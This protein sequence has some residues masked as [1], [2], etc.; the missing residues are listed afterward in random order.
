ME[1]DGHVFSEST[2][3][4]VVGQPREEKPVQLV[5][6]VGFS[7][8]PVIPLVPLPMPV[9]VGGTESSTPRHKPLQD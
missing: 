9:A 2:E 8:E 5:R 4:P 1:I 3:T 7:Q 6:P